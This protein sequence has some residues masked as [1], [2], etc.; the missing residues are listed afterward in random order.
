M[1][2]AGCAPPPPP[3]AAATATGLPV[4]PR[5]GSFSETDWRAACCARRQPGTK[6][7]YKFTLARRTG[8]L[9]QLHDAVADWIVGSCD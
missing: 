4:L 5:L 3:P 8:T 9:G 1:P 7:R 6:P 2:A